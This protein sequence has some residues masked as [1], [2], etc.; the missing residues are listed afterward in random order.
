M[1]LDKKISLIAGMMILFL[2]L[3]P[4]SRLHPRSDNVAE[5]FRNNVVHLSD[6]KKSGFGFVVAEEDGKLYVA[7]ALHVIV[8]D[9][10]DIKP[11]IQVRFYQRQGKVYLAK[12]LELSHKDIDLALLE[13]PKPFKSYKWERKYFHPR[14]R[15]DDEVWFVGRGR[16]W[17][18]PTK[19]GIGSVNIESIAGKIHI[20]MNSVQVGTSGAPLISEKGIVG[21][22]IEDE[23]ADVIAVDID[24][25]RR[26]VTE[27]WRYPWDMEEFP[28]SDRRIATA[29]KLS[30]KATS[31]TTSSSTTTTRPTTT[32]TRA[33]T[34]VPSGPRSRISNSLEMEFVYIQPGNFMMGYSG[35]QHR[36]T[37]SKGFYMQTTEVTQGQWKAVMGSNPPK[38]YFKNCG[39]NCPVERVSWNDVQEFIKKLNRKE[40]TDKYRLPTE[41]EWEYAARA[42]TSTAYSWGDKA[43]CSKMMYENDVGSSEDKCVDYVRRKGLTPDSVA[44]VMS[45][46]PNP[47]GAVRHARER[48]GVVRGLV[49]GLS[50]WLRD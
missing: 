21:M 36:V 7:T 9:D 49:R 17:Y 40:G 37:L 18:I 44:P 19:S 46:A 8:P 29:T 32:T 13:V 6:G 25:I 45:Y 48:L 39:S 30:K 43:D 2:I 28:A 34:T 42:G 47:L 1:R 35:K 12:R 33:T 31:I 50:V 15:R 14:A 23:G 22:I 38:L 24:S 26:V 10:P 41:A 20:D 27:M 4:V 16:N 11:D 5:R 3:W